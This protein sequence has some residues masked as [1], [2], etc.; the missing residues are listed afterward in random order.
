MAA[1]LTFAVAACTDDDDTASEQ[2]WNP[3]NIDL[4][5]Q[6]Q[7]MA[8]GNAEFAV[9]LFANA[10]AAQPGKSLVLSPQSMTYALSM[11]ASGADGQTLTELQ[12]LLGF[13]DCTTDQIDE[14]CQKLMTECAKLDKSI[15]MNTANLLLADNALPVS[16]TYTNTL[17]TFYQ[18]EAA[19]MDFSQKQKVVDY[20]N[21]WSSQKTDGMV[22][23]M[24][25]D[26]GDGQ[27]LILMNAV[28]F[29][30]Q[31]YNKFSKSATRQQTFTREDQST[32][33]VDMMAQE[34]KYL[35]YENDTYQ[36]VDLYYGNG[37]YRMAVLLPKAG[38][39]V[40]DILSAL[41]ST[42]AS[43]YSFSQVLAHLRQAKV[44]L[45]LPKFTTEGRQDYSLLL[46]SMGLEA[47]FS[48]SAN[49]SRL[50]DA[51]I[52]VSQILQGAKIIVDEEGTEAAA[53]TYVSGDLTSPGEPEHVTF[54]ADHPFLYAIH[55]FSTGTIF[56]MGAYCGD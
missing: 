25:D 27:K 45:Q 2:K 9:G 53:V 14:F 6:Q 26:I 29:K 16:A 36:L 28:C 20:V 5:Q 31:W 24:I 22:P 41:T 37:S 55:E 8:S 4:T 1:M 47:P 56:F 40:G 7:Q 21:T 12:R 51:S 35:Y 43:S 38:K 52:H 15:T 39:T 32:T 48:A 11:L 50:T 23:K 34:E 49:F 18:A 44:D 17:K 13:D 3:G 54:T 42:D 19:N 33:K 30:G 46:H 10:Y